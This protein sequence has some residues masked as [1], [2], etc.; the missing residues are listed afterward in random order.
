MVRIITDTT[1]VLS[2]EVARK[3]GIPVI[4]QIIH[5]GQEEYQDGV[6]IDTA[7]FM[8][9]LTAS[10]TLPKTAAPPPSLFVAEFQR[11]AK[12]GDTILCIHPSAEVSGTVRSATIA[13]A[14]FPG[15]DIR[16]IDTRFV[17]SP[18]GTMV[19]LAAEWAA[20]GRSADAIVERLADLTRRCRLYFMVPTLEYLAKGGRIGGAAALVGTVLQ[21]KPILE[22]KDGRVDV[23]ERERTYKRALARLKEMAVEQAAPGEDSRVTVMQAGVPEEGLA[24]AEDL[25]ARMGLARTPP[26]AVMPPSV[27]TQGGPGILGVAFFTRPAGRG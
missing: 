19:E 20:A 4:P 13:K 27:V 3:H 1:A 12:P 18:L 6:D 17:G 15:A 8:Q 25:R 23:L 7:T 16:V 24:L 9:R 11:L 2:P 10:K 21:I 22:F 26:V 5:F 14:E